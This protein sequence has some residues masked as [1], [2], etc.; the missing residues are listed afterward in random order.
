MISRTV[1][2]TTTSTS[3]APR[4]LHSSSVQ[5]SSFWNDADVGGSNST[6]V[7]ARSQSHAAAVGSYPSRDVPDDHSVP[8]LLSLSN[9]SEFDRMAASLVRSALMG[10]AAALGYQI[11]SAVTRH[12]LRWLEQRFSVG[13][14]REDTQYRLF[15]DQGTDTTL[16]KYLCTIQSQMKEYLCR[17]VV[18]FTRKIKIRVRQLRTSI[19]TTWPFLLALASWPSTYTGG[20][21]R[22][23]RQSS[24]VGSL[25]ARSMV[26]QRWVFGPLI[27][28]W[29]L[30][31]K[32]GSDN[33]DEL[34][35]DGE[36][37]PPTTPT[38][39]EP[40]SDY[41]LMRRSSST[42]SQ[43]SE[44]AT[45]TSVLPHQQSQLPKQQRYL[46]MLVHNVSHTDL[47]LGIGLKKH[48]MSGG[49]MKALMTPRQTEREQMA[50]EDTKGYV[51]AGGSGHDTTDPNEKY[52]LCRPRFSAFDLF[53]R[54]ILD[55]VRSQM[56]LG[57]SHDALIESVVS[58]PRYKRSDA[59]SRYNLVT[60]KVKNRERMLP[61]GFDLE[62][63]G[64]DE[65]MLAVQAN[66]IPSLR[67]RGRDV[68]KM[69]SALQSQWA[70]ADDAGASGEF[71]PAADGP[72]DVTINGV[73]FPLLA[74]LLR[75]WHADIADKYDTNGL[76]GRDE[77][78]KVKK[79][80]VLV[81]GVGS[82]RNWTHSIT[83][84]STQACAE[85]QEIFIK[86]LYPDVTVVRI[87]SDTNIFRYDENISFAK[88]ELMPCVNAYRDAHA[89][90]LPYPDE[91]QPEHIV[92][93]KFDPDWKQSFA[94]A[95]SFADG[96]PA[97]THAIQTSLRQTYRPTYYHL[98]H[99]KTFWHDSKLSDEDIE[100]HP[101]EEME[102]VPALD[103]AKISDQE[104]QI[105]INEMRAF[106]KYFLETL[107]ENS[108]DIKSFWL[109]KTKKP[110][111][112]ILLVAD[113]RNGGKP[114][115]YRGSNMEVSMPTGSLCAERNVIGTAL[116]SNP[117][118]KR[119]DLKMV[120]VLA[121]PLGKDESDAAALPPQ[122][123]SPPPGFDLGV[124]AAV[125]SVVGSPRHAAVGNAITSTDSSA[126][127]SSFPEGSQFL[128]EVQQKLENE[129]KE[130]KVISASM[131]RSYSTTSFS[132]ILEEKRSRGNSKGDDEEDDD[133]SPLS[134]TIADAPAT[135]KSTGS[136]TS[137]N[138]PGTVAFHE[139]I[140]LVR[141]HSNS[142]TSPPGTPMRKIKLSTNS[143]FRPTFGSSKTKRTV[144]V[145]SPDDINP[146]APCG[147]CNEWLKKIAESNPYF[148]VLTF[149]DADCNGVYITPVIE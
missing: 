43:K 110:V 30:C 14:G 142:I 65:R 85:L 35:D 66:E 37:M 23:I 21:M 105:V 109:R 96:S 141:K 78:R 20:S 116:A 100:V 71:A 15:S 122:V 13:N 119:E 57:D 102:T 106:R 93:G 137:P 112:A 76:V 62:S 84:N 29:L 7:D 12:V 3:P 99:L 70:E 108:N 114:K 113:A 67:V 128:S 73:F 46:E 50:D 41:D 4:G 95:L 1:Q 92:P 68:A 42:F 74:I 145:H 111:L 64:D 81:S 143:N 107:D 80:L 6:Y 25:E 26:F 39:N 90:G 32:D 47:I 31:A 69:G 52:A 51:V 48:G 36:N 97:R 124:C 149:T 147:A 134:W 77:G 123:P 87:H 2:I 127:D 9:A 40:L 79:V 49:G 28:G 54:R 72:S 75:R 17:A 58:F 131:A 120:A 148:K 16:R 94:V 61:V 5:S 86:V 115:L 126:A 144:V 138:K 63:E 55:S 53:S 60:P 82:P 89:R 133:D 140:N 146:L 33:D 91:K 19:G 11:T 125:G 118:L 34:E 135:D 38:R 129:A 24:E 103:V 22:H 44:S 88:E 101:F 132:S 139:S 83:G 56:L 18:R 136:S 8:S 45:Q 130:K 121:I 104:V 59:S 98:W 27:L 117:G 10:A